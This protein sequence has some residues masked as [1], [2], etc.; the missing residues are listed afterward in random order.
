METSFT[1]LVLKPWANLFLLVS[2]PGLKP[3]LGPG[4]GLLN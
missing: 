3:G 1:L 4:L 2:K